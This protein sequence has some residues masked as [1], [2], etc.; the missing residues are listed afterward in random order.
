[1]ATS[2]SSSV[3]DLFK[4]QIRRGELKVGQK[5]PTIRDVAAR[6]NLA[7]ATA[8]RVVDQLVS[9]GYIERF[10]R[11]PAVVRGVPVKSLL[12]GVVY[13]SSEANFRHPMAVKFL[14]ALTEA[15]LAHGHR[16]Q[17]LPVKDHD[18]SNVLDFARD[19]QPSSS[20]GLFM[21]GRASAD[22][23][24]DLPTV[25][26]RDYGVPIVQ[27]EVRLNDMSQI[28]P[29]LMT[30]FSDLGRQAIN[31][32]HQVGRKRIGAIVG[33]WS[34]QSDPHSTLAGIA[35]QMAELGLPWNESHLERISQWSEANGRQAAA[36]LLDKGDFDAIL[37]PDDIVALG[38]L[39]EIKS[40]GLRVPQ[41][42][43]LI[44][45]GDLLPPDSDVKMSTFEMQCESL[46]RHAVQLFERM[47]DGES[48]IGHDALV[49]PIY[50]P[51]KTCPAGT[52]SEQFA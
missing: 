15:H 38:V 1:M 36:R 3:C 45:T 34:K 9:E 17:L 25:A 22:K 20:G 30:D 40:R 29:L 18:W 44:G 48:F 33:P 35:A 27:F 16:I 19:L 26:L 2:V 14:H 28:W 50:K 49:P 43:V 31:I 23:Q 11:R 32:F 42:V 13:G 21:F 52:P 5:F 51:R 37:C 24:S 10:G 8:A 6:H 47:A 41:D 12:I 7:Y 39:K 4:S 46:A